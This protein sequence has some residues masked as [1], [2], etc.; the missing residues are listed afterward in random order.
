MW[1]GTANS[2]GGRSPQ[3]SAGT[4]NNTREPAETR[5]SP[6]LLDSFHGL[7][8]WISARVYATAGSG[9]DS[10]YTVSGDRRSSEL[11]GRLAL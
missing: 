2:G 1:P 7:D 8:K 11:C 6:G 5:G 4:P 3:A 9:I 10:K